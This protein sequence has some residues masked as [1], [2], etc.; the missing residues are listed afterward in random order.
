M[1][2]FVVSVAGAHHARCTRLGEL[3]RRVPRLLWGT[4]MRRVPKHTWLMI[5]ASVLVTTTRGCGTSSS[6][7]TI[8]WPRV[9]TAAASPASTFTVQTAPTTVKGETITILTEGLGRILYSFT[10]DTASKT[11]C[12]GSC[13]QTRPRCSSS[14]P[15]SPRP[16]QSCRGNKRCMRIPMTIPRTPLAETQHPDKQMV[17]DFLEN[18]LQQHLI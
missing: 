15:A 17:K 13:A 11:L 18:G 5:R 3:T 7:P 12:T 14:E 16:P 4:R 6:G 8:R 2:C 1:S 10:S 9:P